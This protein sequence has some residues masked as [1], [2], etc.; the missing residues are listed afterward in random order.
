VSIKSRTYFFKLI[1]IFR[2]EKDEDNNNTFNYY[3]SKVRVHSEH[4]VGFLKGRWQSLH[5]LRVRINQPTHLQ[6]ATLWITTCV[7]LHAFAMEHEGG[8]DLS[9]DQFYQKG[10]ELMQCERAERENR[11][12]ERE[13]HATASQEEWEVARDI[14]LLEG[15]L[16]RE[17]LKKALFSHLYGEN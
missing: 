6:Y 11:L 12:V 15:K 1:I 17:E 10:R 13:R 3:V 9:A 5:G 4:C 7:L 8:I 2:P 16:K 14:E